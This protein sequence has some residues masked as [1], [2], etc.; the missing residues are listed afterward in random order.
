MSAHQAGQN[1]RGLRR[2]KQA[3]VRVEKQPYD[4]RNPVRTPRTAGGST[5]GVFWCQ[6]TGTI[7]AASGTWGSLTLGELTG[8]TVY[9]VSGGAQVKVS[10]NATIYNSW[11][12][13][14]AASKTTSLQA[15]GDGTYS[16][17]NQAC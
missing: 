16:L 5:V 17:D 4:F 11:P 10:T 9:R 8:Q 3:T 15:N 13:S 12:T 1:R 14:F 2:V 7:S 6:L